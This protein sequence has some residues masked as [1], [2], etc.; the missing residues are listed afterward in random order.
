MVIKMLCKE[1]PYMA[2]SRYIP[3][4]ELSTWTPGSIS[5]SQF[6]VP[7]LGSNRSHA[8]C[9][10]DESP[11]SERHQRLCSFLSAPGRRGH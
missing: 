6:D 7:S 8:N 1:T 10:D 2:V 11:E 4:G 9:R 5:M 3:L